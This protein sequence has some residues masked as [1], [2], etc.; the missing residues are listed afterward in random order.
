MKI[1]FALLTHLSR[2]KEKIQKGCSSFFSYPLHDNPM[3][4]TSVFHSNRVK[5]FLFQTLSIILQTYIIS[6]SNESPTRNL[7]FKYQTDVLYSM[8]DKLNLGVQNVSCNFFSGIP[9]T[10]DSA[11]RYFFTTFCLM[12]NLS[13]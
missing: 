7:E 9:P 2:E 4:C 11:T 6:S 5:Y 3:Y 10:V 1:I 12:R 8:L 13:Y